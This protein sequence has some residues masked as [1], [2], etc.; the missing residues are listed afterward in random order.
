LLG[1]LDDAHPNIRI[2]LHHSDKPVQTQ[3]GSDFSWCRI[4]IPVDVSHKR[5]GN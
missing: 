4:F 3:V 2:K 5:S 1:R